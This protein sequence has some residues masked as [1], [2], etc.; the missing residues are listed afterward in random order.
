MPHQCALLGEACGELTP[1]CYVY[2]GGPIC[3]GG[4]C[5]LEE[6]DSCVSGGE[7]C[8]GLSCVEA[9]PFTYTECRVR[10]TTSTSTTSTTSAPSTSTTLL[11]LAQGTGCGQ[12]DT[13]CAG[14]DCRP[15]YHEGKNT[16][17]LCLPPCPLS[18]DLTGPPQTVTRPPA[19]TATG[20]YN[21]TFVTLVG[22]PFPTCLS[23]APDLDCTTGRTDRIIDAETGT[24][25]TNPAWPPITNPEFTK[26]WLT[27]GGP[28]FNGPPDNR[29]NFGLVF[30]NYNVD[31]TGGETKEL[32]LM[33]HFA[34]Q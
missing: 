9:S 29:A 2:P 24:D 15:N 32:Y 6:G 18:F 30:Y 11:C 31:G 14:L 4:R 8:N 5:C 12:G 21:E 22:G 3:E 19:P 33:T 34:C 10:P 1:C 28:G 16:A 26:D 27:Y 23:P 20:S 17:M 13:C 7:C 25:L